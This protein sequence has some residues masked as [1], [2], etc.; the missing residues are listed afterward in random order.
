MAIQDRATRRSGSAVVMETVTLPAS[1]RWCGT[2]ARVRSTR[3]ITV[4]WC[5]VNSTAQS[6][7][8]RQANWPTPFLLMVNGRLAGQPD[9]PRK[10]RSHRRKPSPPLPRHRPKI[11]RLPLLHRQAVRPTKTM[12]PRLQNRMR[13]LRCRQRRNRPRLQSLRDRLLQQQR[14]KSSKRRAPPRKPPTPRTP[15]SLPQAT[16]ERVA[17]P[18]SKRITKRRTPNTIQNQTSLRKDQKPKQKNQPTTRSALSPSHCRNRL[19]QR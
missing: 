10:L 13:S 16:L 17:R 9:R 3:V 14:R 5:A 15:T 19:G 18:R 12:E 2:P 11:R 1:A 7:R 4:K 8:V 6:I